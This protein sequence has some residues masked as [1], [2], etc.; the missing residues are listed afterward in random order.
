VNTPEADRRASEGTGPA[1]RA[2]SA[3]RWERWWVAALCLA[4]AARVTFGAAALPFFADTDEAF[5]YD[6]VHKFARGHWPGK[7]LEYLDPETVE[8]WIF[9]GSPE[10]LNA[11][12]SLDARIPDG[13]PPPL[14]D[15]QRTPA[16]AVNVRQQLASKGALPN[17][18]AHSPP[19]YYALAG[20]WCDVGRALG[21][22]GARSVWWVRFLNAP[23]YAAAVA[24][25]YAFCRPAFGGGVALAAGVLAAAFPNTVFFTANSD[26]LSPAAGGLVLLLLFRWAARESPAAGLAAAAGAVLAAAVLVK[27]TTA[28]LL[29]PAAGA[30]A[31]RLTG[32]GRVAARE[33]ALFALAAGLPLAAWGLHN[34]LTLGDWT[35]TAEKVRQLTWAAKPLPEVFH[36][37]L[38]T[39]GGLVT[40]LK[41]LGISSFAGDAS[42]NARTVHSLPAE[43]FFFAT[44]AVLPAMGLVAAWRRPGGSRL[45]A[46]LAALAVAGA[47]GVL[48]LLSLRFDFGECPFPSRAFPYLTSGRLVA[49]A[50]VPFVA[51]YA[52]GLDALCGRRP[53]LLAAAT[54]GTVAVMAL[55]QLTYLRPAVSSLYNWFHLP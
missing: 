38:F 51:L 48:V 7:G 54:A 14:R 27:L 39:A 15:W 53:A 20:L 2:V 10:F 17:Y 4:A 12:G 19:A 32:R 29:A 22:M 42:W 44:A 49:G 35:G 5:H 6:L 16:T 8:V 33:V 11:P 18:E 40:F 47:V 24:L 37:P 52:R 43:S 1:S 26:A 28:A 36:H 21:Q 13:Y 46:G 23:L 34:W 41:A 30:A 9:D 50:L 55:M 3:G 45:A 25:A 31:A